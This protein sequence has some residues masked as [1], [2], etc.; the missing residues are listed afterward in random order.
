MTSLQKEKTIRH[1]LFLIAVDRYELTEIVLKRTQGDTSH[2]LCQAIALNLVYLS[3]VRNERFDDI[4]K[5]LRN[6]FLVN[7]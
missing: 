7:T 4:P 1:L 3:L 5:D 2:N 6:K